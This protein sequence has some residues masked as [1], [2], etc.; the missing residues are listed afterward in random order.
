M[1]KGVPFRRDYTSNQRGRCKILI[2]LCP[3]CSTLI[4]TKVHMLTMLASCTSGEVNSWMALVRPRNPFDL[5]YSDLPNEAT[6]RIQSV[7]DVQE[8]YGCA[9]FDPLSQ[10]SHCLQSIVCISSRSRL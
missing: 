8:G 7:Q 4:L 10:A 2:L 3:C 6:P 9:M 5:D 1:P